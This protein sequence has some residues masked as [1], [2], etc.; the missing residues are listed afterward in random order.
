MNR[1][2]GVIMMSEGALGG[3]V[4]AKEI[5]ATVNLLSRFNAIDLAVSKY[6]LHIKINNTNLMLML[7]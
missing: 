2:R 6:E 1:G 7:I 3:G 4:A 5:Q